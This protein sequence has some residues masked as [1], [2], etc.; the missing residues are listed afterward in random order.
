M[1]KLKELHIIWML[2]IHNKNT[3][4]NIKLKNINLYYLRI[5]KYYQL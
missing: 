2:D 3:I 5:H 4:M 1:L